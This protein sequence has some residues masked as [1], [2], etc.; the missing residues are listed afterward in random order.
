M[1]VYTRFSMRFTGDLPTEEWIESRFALLKKITL[2]SL[3]I[4][5]CERFVWLIGASTEWFD[6]T[7]ALFNDIKVRPGIDIEVATPPVSE[8][9]INRIHQ[10]ADSFVTIRLDSDDAFHKEALFR[11]RN[12]CTTVPDKYLIDMPNGVKLEWNSREML[13]CKHHDTY[14]GPFFAVKHNTRENMFFIGR[15]HKNAREDFNGWSSIREES[16]L[17][18][19][20]GGNLQ[21]Q[22]HI[23]SLKTKIKSRFGVYP[24][25]GSAEITTV[26]K[27]LRSKILSNYGIDL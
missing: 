12:H 23:H 11:L 16:W 6:K 27:R 21:N 22:F 2:P 13:Y 10:G 25:N 15:E 5:S 24:K 7:S 9:I 26:P 14:Q 19:I 20:H 1:T 3:N 8:Q 18:V 17:Q 4:Q